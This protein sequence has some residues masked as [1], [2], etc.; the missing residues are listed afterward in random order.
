MSSTPSTAKRA[1]NFCEGDKKPSPPPPQQTEVVASNA[2]A[3]G[4]NTKRIWFSLDDQEDEW[5][6]NKQNSFNDNKLLNGKVHFPA[7]QIVSQKRVKLEYH[8][9]TGNVFIVFQKLPE[10]GNGEQ[11]VELRLDVVQW[12]HLQTKMHFIFD[13]IKAVEGK[14]GKKVS[15]VLNFEEARSNIKTLINWSNLTLDLVDNLKLVLRWNEKLKNSSVEI[16]RF[17]AVEE[18]EIKYMVKGKEG[19]CFSAGGFDYLHRYL[20]KKITNGVRMWSNMH[21]SGSVL[22]ESCMSTYKQKPEYFERNWCKFKPVEDDSDLN[23]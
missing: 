22:W 8:F 14:N 13:F 5:W 23:E 1:L 19:I 21:A 11:I 12:G 6:I 20:S 17:E 16:R 15:D 4:T 3:V 18:G 2:A 7:W 10:F 9:A